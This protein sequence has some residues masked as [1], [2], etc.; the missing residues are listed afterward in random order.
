MIM[1]AYKRHRIKT[2]CTSNCRTGE[3]DRHNNAN[4][5]N[6][7]GCTNKM[8]HAKCKPNQTGIQ[9]YIVSEQMHAVGI[10]SEQA[11]ILEISKKD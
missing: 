9:V 2:E 11:Q 7:E 6:L 5:K 1:C 4:Y 10:V 3:Q 8:R